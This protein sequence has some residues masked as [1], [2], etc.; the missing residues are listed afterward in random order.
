MREQLE[1]HP[2]VASY[3]PGDHHEGGDGVTVAELVSR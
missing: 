3:R 2:L 1:E